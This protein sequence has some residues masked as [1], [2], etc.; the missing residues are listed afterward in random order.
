MAKKLEIK[1]VDFFEPTEPSKAKETIENIDVSF[2]DHFPHH[3]FKINNIDEMA[4]TIKEHGILSPL[5]LRPNPEHE[6]RYQII[7]GHRRFEGARANEFAFVPAI[8]KDVDNETA[9]VMMVDTNL[10]GQRQNILL[11]EK[12]FAYKMKL[13]AIKRQAGRPSKNSAQVGPNYDGK[14]SRD[15]VADQSGESRNQISRYIRLTELI[16]PL[17]DMVDEGRIKFIP[18]VELSYLPKQNQEDLLSLLTGDGNEKGLLPPSQQ[19][20][21][22]MRKLSEMGKLD[23]DSMEE[24]MMNRNSNEFPKINFSSIKQYF[25]RGVTPKEATKKISYALGLEK[26]TERYFNPEMPEEKRI[27]ITQKALDFYLQHRNRQE[28]NANNKS[29]QPNI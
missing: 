19:Q 21:S 28:I 7:A 9:I 26:A 10:D 12:A 16:P 23:K 15:I 6:G 4:Q 18:S 8:V 24:I 13:E 25:G 5:I 14:Q 22:E 3:P 29:N 1:P 2:I 11:S 17:L 27:A 20:A